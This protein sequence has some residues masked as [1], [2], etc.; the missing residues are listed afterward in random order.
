MSL[1][2]SKF[3]E[4]YTNYHSFVDLLNYCKEI[5]DYIYNND[6]TESVYFY[7]FK[8]TKKGYNIIFNK[9]GK[10][11]YFIDS[12]KKKIVNQDGEDQ[13]IDSV[14]EELEKLYNKIKTDLSIIN[15]QQ[16]DENINQIDEEIRSFDFI[17]KANKINESFSDDLKDKLSEKYSSLKIGIIKLLNETLDGDQSKL[18]DYINDYM[19]EESDIILEG[20][21]ED[22]DI[23][24]FYLKYQSDID[25]ILLDNDYYDDPPEVESLYN[26]VINGTVDA[27]FYCMKKIKNDLYD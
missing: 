16:I 3:L 15:I 8:E 26:Y 9:Y 27:V 5:S 11:D 14:Y 24:D 12:S 20:F 13:I 4:Q 17:L 22:A 18:E 7:E 25:Q 10:N 2:F 23:F 21:I 1:V 6:I 19:D